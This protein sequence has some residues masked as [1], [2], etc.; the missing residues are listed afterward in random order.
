MEDEGS[1]DNK[2]DEPTVSAARKLQISLKL[3]QLRRLKIRNEI[4][5]N[6]IDASTSA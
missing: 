6:S 4:F 2:A 5:S 1:V 3:C